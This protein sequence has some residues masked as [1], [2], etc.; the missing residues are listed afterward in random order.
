MPEE[1]SMEDAGGRPTVPLVERV[2]IQA[3]L[4]VPLVQA[5]E[6]ELGAERAQDLVRRVLGEHYRRLASR[7]VGQ[8]GSLGAMETFVTVSMSGG[9]V[10]RANEE[11]SATEM[12]FEVTGCRYAD[13]FRA[14]GEPELGFLLVCTSDFAL[15][16][17][18][19]GVTL[20]RTQ[21]IMQ[22]APSCDFLYHFDPG[23][24]RTVDD[25]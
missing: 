18:M 14:I 21:T 7:W 24:L 25:G 4:L 12:A 11:R 19:P 8:G 16:E 1:D 20:E 2:K 3:E 23:E 5:L 10:D 15:A 6:Q 17:G 22:G 13:F 9:A